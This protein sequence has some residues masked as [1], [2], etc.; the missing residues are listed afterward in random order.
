DPNC[1]NRLIAAFYKMQILFTVPLAVFGAFFASFAVPAVFG[2]DMQQAGL[3]ASGFC[4]IHLFPMISTPLSMAIQAKEQVHRMLPLMFLQISVN[5]LL[6][7]LL[8]V[9]LDLGVWGGMAAVALTFIITIPFRLKVVRKIIGGIYFPIAY[10]LRIGIPLVLLAAM[11]S[12]ASGHWKLLD[13]FEIR[14]LNV[15]MLFIL[16]ILYLILFLLCI[17]VFRL[18][19]EEDIADF[20]ALNIK[21][22]NFIFDLL[23]PR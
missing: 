1:L 2:D 20:R 23:R 16:G 5:L 22:L 21:R 14:W 8:I 17:R 7:W 18:I 13:I 4:L 11:L 10:F 12:L 15:A 6:D 19:R 9:V 3:I